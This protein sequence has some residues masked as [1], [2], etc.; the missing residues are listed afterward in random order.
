MDFLA[1]WREP[2][3]GVAPFL[4]PSVG[5]WI[6]WARTEDVSVEDAPSPAHREAFEIYQA[7]SVRVNLGT[8]PQDWQQF[9]VLSAA[10]EGLLHRGT[11]GV[12]D[13]TFYGRLFE[14]LR[15]QDAPL[16]ARAAADFLYGVASWEHQRTLAATPILV[17]AWQR[18]EE[19]VPEL[20]FRDGAILAYLASGNPGGAGE[21]LDLC[22]GQRSEGSQEGELDVPLEILR[23]L[24]E[25]GQLPAG[26]EETG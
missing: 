9:M 25:R 12:A 21:I 6:R 1:D 26:Q 19:W 8:P 15:S 16:E 2:V 14:Y 3:L 5:S 11:S 18:E 13:S 22:S 7:F 17:E 24:V 20:L 10:V 4:G 23:V